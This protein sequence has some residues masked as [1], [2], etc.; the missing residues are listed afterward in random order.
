M[1]ARAGTQHFG[2]WF[3]MSIEE[4]HQVVLYNETESLL[5]ISYV[6][7]LESRTA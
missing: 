5:N 7:Y 6:I 3:C 4:N 1:H 2:P